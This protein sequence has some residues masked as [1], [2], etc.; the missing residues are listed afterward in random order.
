MIDSRP[1]ISP[2]ADT[3]IHYLFASPGNEHILLSFVNA[4]RDSVRLPPVKVVQVLSPF[5]PQTFAMEKLSIID[6]KAVVDNHHLVVIEFQMAKQSAFARRAL[7]YWAKTFSTQLS[8]GENY[9]K[10]SP[11]TMII[12][13]RFLLFGELDN[14]HNLFWITAQD[15]PEILFTD[16]LQIHTLE[17]EDTKLGQLP[18]IKKPLRGWLEFFYYADKKSEEEMKGLLETSGAPALGEAYD[19]YIRFNQN[20]EL[21]HLN[22]MREMYLHDITTETD[23][24][25]EEGEI[26]GK[27][28]SIFAILEAH[29]GEVP[30][31]ICHAVA[32]IGDLDVLDQL[33]VLAVK[34]E[35]LDEFLSAMK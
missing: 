15:N 18:A 9:K 34:C 21:R 6:I 35:S 26:K 16:C 17:L 25:R 30:Q 7:Y 11:V 8:Y 5:N 19:I 14:L 24:A 23:F 22:D 10:L 27:V 13:T 1:L 20:P 33:T 31:A 32:Q 28:D 29:F 2:T 4:V 12:L 3:F